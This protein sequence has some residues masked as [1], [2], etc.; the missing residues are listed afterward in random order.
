MAL[1]LG[2]SGLRAVHSQVPGTQVIGIEAARLQRPCGG[3]ISGPARRAEVR[4]P[5][6]EQPRHRDQNEMGVQLLLD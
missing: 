4:V 5:V 2:S 3:T 6:G 1:A